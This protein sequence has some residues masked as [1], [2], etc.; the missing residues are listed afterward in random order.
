MKLI[1]GKG[2][3]TSVKPG[4]VD[5]K[6]AFFLLLE[7][8]NTKHYRFSD[9]SELIAELLSEIKDLEA[10]LEEKQETIDTLAAKFERV[11]AKVK[12]IKAEMNRG[13]SDA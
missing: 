3:A 8:N 7:D 4:L 1:D 13:G 9:E 12:A 5:S 11:K 6:G 2:Y 10:K